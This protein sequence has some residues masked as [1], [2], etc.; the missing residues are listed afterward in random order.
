MKIL[1]ATSS[2]T[3][4]AG[5][6]SYNREICSMLTKDNEMHL[7]VEEDIYSYPGYLKVF[8]ISHI[9]E[10]SYRDCS[11]LLIKINSEKYDLIINSNSHIMA[12][13]APFIND[14][15][16]IITVSHSLRYTDSDNAVFNNKYIDYIIALSEYNKKHISHKWGVSD[17]VNVIYNFVEDVPNS[18]EMRDSK[19]NNE[20]IKIVYAGGTAPSKNPE[21]VLRVLSELLQTDLNFHFVMMGVKTPPIKRYQPFSDVSILIPNDDRVVFTGKIPH[22][23]ASKLIRECNI[24]FAPSRREGCPMALLEALSV[25]VIPIVSDYKIANKE[26]ITDGENGFVIN[27]KKVEEFVCRISD[28]IKNHSN[29]LNVYDKSFH[30]FQEKLSYAVWEEKMKGLFSASKKNHRERK[31]KM[32]KSAFFYNKMRFNLMHKCN[33]IEKVLCETLP[34]AWH[35]FRMYK[36]CNKR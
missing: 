20:V 35:I 13:L 26:I 30:T 8:S 29:Y 7:L 33:E 3:P 10:S 22:D 14:S 21:L 12:R 27:H 36:Q 9:N 34:S 25:G 24:F 4:N 6:P 19:K 16:K 1:L 5:I 15:T 18:H 28:I 11:N 31:V 17:K 23:E 32:S 2:V